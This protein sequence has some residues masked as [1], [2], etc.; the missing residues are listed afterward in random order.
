P[1]AMTMAKYPGYS[2]ATTFRRVVAKR[3]EGSVWLGALATI[4]TPSW[5]RPV[6]V[7]RGQDFPT[8]V[9]D[10]RP[11]LVGRQG[12]REWGYSRRREPRGDPDV[13]VFR[14]ATCLEPGRGEIGG[15]NGQSGRRGAVSGARRAMAGGAE[16]VVRSA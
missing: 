8:E 1:V 15:W 10:E 13:E 6:V 7:R 3:T 4:V 11:D 14:L 2:P 12:G 9:R 16:S 5:L